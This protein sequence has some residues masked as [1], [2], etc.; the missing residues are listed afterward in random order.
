MRYSIE[1]FLG[2]RLQNM[3]VFPILLQGLLVLTFL[4]HQT[5]LPMCKNTS[6]I[7]IIIW[8]HHRN[9]LSNFLSVEQIRVCVTYMFHKIIHPEDWI[10]NQFGLLFLLL[11]YPSLLS[12]CQCAIT[13][14]R[15]DRSQIFPGIL[16]FLK[17]RLL[18]CFT[19]LMLYSTSKKLLNLM[20]LVVISSLATR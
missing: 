15:A 20:H 11:R 12:P 9:S 1:L 6:V 18:Q 14:T 13:C 16:T 4:K 3:W 10:R 7:W 17:L 2:Y 8:L 5:S 19:Y